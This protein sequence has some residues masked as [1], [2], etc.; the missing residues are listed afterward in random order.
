MSKLFK[1]EMF[2][3]VAGCAC[4]TNRRVSTPLRSASPFLREGRRGGAA[5]RHARG[6]ALLARVQEEGPAARQLRRRAVRRA[7]GAAERCSASPG[8]RCPLPVCVLSLLGFSLSVCL[9]AR[10]AACSSVRSVGR[11]VGRSGRECSYTQPGVSGWRDIPLYSWPPP[12]DAGG[13]PSSR[14][15]ASESSRAGK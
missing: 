1:K 14:T 4:Q 6:G 13:A 11:S 3:R 8:F 12:S 15:R 2:S 9:V 7:S 5:P 10:S